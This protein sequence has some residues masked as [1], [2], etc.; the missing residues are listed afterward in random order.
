MPMPTYKKAQRTRLHLAKKNDRF[1]P[2]RWSVNLIQGKCR[3]IS[4][5]LRVD[6]CIVFG[7]KT[8]LLRHWRSYRGASTFKVW[9]VEFKSRV[10]LQCGLKN[11]ASFRFFVRNNV[12]HFTEK[13][14]IRRFC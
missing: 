6:D 1:H 10:F 3:C 14:N 12:S 5:S 4:T 2:G 11:M 7:Y 13:M 9:R 8:S